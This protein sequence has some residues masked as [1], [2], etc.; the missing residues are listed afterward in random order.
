MTEIMIIADDLTGAADT[1]VR[2]LSGGQVKMAN[3]DRPGR[4]EGVWGLAVDTESRN[5]PDDCIREIMRKTAVL[6]R[7]GRPIIIY[8]KIDSCLRGQIGWELA[9]LLGELNLAGA[10][11][12]PAYPDL[13]RVTRDGLHYVGDCLVSEGESSMDPFRPVT[14][15]RL[16]S[17]LERNHGLPVRS[18]GLETVRK[19]PAAVLEAILPG[20]QTTRVLW[21]ADAETNADL[22]VLAEAGLEASDRLILCGSAGLAGA[23]SRR[24]LGQGEKAG[25]NFRPPLANAGGPRPTMFL[26]GSTSAVLKEQ[27]DVLVERE[28][29]KRVTLN[30]SEVLD[31]AWV[32]TG[33]LPVSLKE[34]EELLT[35]GPLIVNLPPRQGQGL[36]SSRQIIDAFG[37]LA[38]SLITELQ[39]GCLFI[40]GGDT[41]NAVLNAL[42]VSAG[43]LKAEVEPGVALLEA[44]PW[45]IL[46]KSGG[47]G[48]RELL[49]RLYLGP[50]GNPPPVSANQTLPGPGP[51]VPNQKGSSKDESFPDQEPSGER[52]SDQ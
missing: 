26:A 20:S 34:S 13:G 19:G 21:A 1:G 27:L 47:F 5:A 23:L 9:M 45:S 18:L 51:K 40:S 16:S 4:L 41:A 42:G 36:H 31:L 24:L 29:A 46:T 17:V 2:F 50:N 15:S 38:A 8:K 3:L 10:L 30:I 11:V 37:I 43:W 22:D 39:P 33:T 44:G 32:K 52:G 48:D 14:D 35:K 25:T 6:V 12:A 7:E 28:G 49:R